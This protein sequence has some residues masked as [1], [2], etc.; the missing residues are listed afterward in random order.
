MADS[1]TARSRTWAL[2]IRRTRTPFLFLLLSLVVALPAPPVHAHGADSE[3]YTAD[4]PT[5]FVASDAA[6]CLTLEEPCSEFEDCLSGADEGVSKESHPFQ[7]EAAGQL[8]V[9]MSEFSGDW[10]LYLLD[11]DGRELDSSAGPASDTT[12][13]VAAT[14]NGNVP[15]TIVACNFSGGPTANVNISFIRAAVVSV[16]DVAVHEG[17][18]GTRS[19]VFTVSLSK[20]VAATVSV[21]YAT[22]KDSALGT[23]FTAKSGT[24]T[25]PA[26]ATSATV[27][28]PVSG[29]TD[30]EPDESFNLVLSSPVGTAIGDG[31]GVGTII[32]DDPTTGRRLAIGDV[33]VHEGDAEGRAAVFTVSLSKSSTGYVT[34]NFATVK[35]TAVGADFTAT[36]GTLTFSPGSTSA[37]VKVPITADTAAEGNE[38]F[39]VKLSNSNGPTISDATGL[40]TIIDND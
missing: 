33:S 17:D 1:R 23:D 32:D 35:G 27:K 12:E 4:A 18:A 40:G 26:G 22:A 31:T 14:L 37:T 24:V 2:T 3:T 19:P 36:S 13:T 30:D 25:F 7:L 10:D 5:P 6:G 29:D 28:V 38:T 16:G 9:V 20:P 15:V 39:T 8:T 34:V 11:A 21:A